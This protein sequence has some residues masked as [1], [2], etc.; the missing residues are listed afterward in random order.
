[1]MVAPLHIASP[2]SL[3]Y[4]YDRLLLFLNIS[5]CH[6]RYELGAHLFD[7]NI[8]ARYPRVRV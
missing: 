6:Q 7:M 8:F 5:R 3:Q 1:M 2:M 4:L